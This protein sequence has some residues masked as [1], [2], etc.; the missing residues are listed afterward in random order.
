MNPKIKKLEAERDK[1]K[2]RIS[3][4]NARQRE[5]DQQIQELENL[6]ILGVVHSHNLDAAAL[7]AFL[8]QRNNGTAPRMGVVAKEDI[9]E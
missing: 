5:I 1:N 8:A 6:D 9:E 2:Q 4:I 7:A 3:D